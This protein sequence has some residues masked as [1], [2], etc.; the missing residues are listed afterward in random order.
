[1]ARR[2]GI[3]TTLALAAAAVAMTVPAHARPAAPQ[4]TGKTPGHGLVAGPASGLVKPHGATVRKTPN[5]TYHGGVVMPTSK[6]KAIFW[7][8]SWGTY[9]G[10]KVTGID[11]FYNGF[12]N[13]NYAKT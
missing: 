1:M 11:S 12:S 2:F 8:T 6:V 3:L 5:M 9:T 4:P 10:D 13:S 7:G